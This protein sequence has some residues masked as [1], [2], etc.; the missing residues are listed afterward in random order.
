MATARDAVQCLML[1][2]AILGGFSCIARPDFNFPLYLY[3]WW[4][5][6]YV[7]EDRKRQQHVMVFFMMFSCVQDTIF[8]FYWPSRWFSHEWLALT[9]A[10]EGV[11]IIA[12]VVGIVE[13]GLKALILASLL[14]PGITANTAEITKRWSGSN[15]LIQL[16]MPA[17]E[18]QI[19]LAQPMG[20]G[21]HSHTFP[22]QSV[23][24]YA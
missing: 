19:R 7:P 18:P 3:L 12:T 20:L 4:A 17:T 9:S 24:G 10:E 1:C 16:E 13:L 21:R 14:V 15:G 5:F 2:V 22:G 8:L 11:H 6:F 23:M